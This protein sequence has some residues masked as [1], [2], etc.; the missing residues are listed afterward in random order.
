MTASPDDNWRG[1]SLCVFC[2]GSEAA[3]AAHVSSARSLGRILGERGIRLIFGGGEIGLMGAVARGCME[4][5][6]VTYGVIPEFI[7]HLERPC[8]GLSRLEV[9]QTM[10][11]RTARMH[12][13]ADAFVALP[14]GIGTLEEVLEFSTYRSLGVHDKHI[15]LVNLDDFWRP[16]FRVF[17]AMA[18]L[19][20][21]REPWEPLFTVINSETEV[22]ATL[23]NLKLL[24]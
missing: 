5:G 8:E 15:I 21:F 14:G 20:Y 22:V 9:V 16:L 18:E 2:G 19:G 13:L 6:G 23:E 17:E 1:L 12:A 3:P 4:T 7:T 24:R 10:H 11:E